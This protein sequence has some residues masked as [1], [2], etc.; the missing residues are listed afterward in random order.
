MYFNV[1]SIKGFIYW[2]QNYSKTSVTIKMYTMNVLNTVVIFRA[3]VDTSSLW[4]HVLAH[5]PGFVV[6]VQFKGSTV[7]GKIQNVVVKQKKLLL[8]WF[9]KGI[10]QLQAAAGVKSR[11]HVKT[12]SEQCMDHWVK[13]RGQTRTESQWNGCHRKRGKLCNEKWIQKEI[14]LTLNWGWEY[15]TLYLHV[16]S[17]RT[18]LKLLW[19]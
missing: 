8:S 2:N 10:V 1:L 14:G 13:E 7:T 11:T 19:R 5:R 12:W 18:C 4:E 16:L 9:I 3:V 6:N 17:T 15:F